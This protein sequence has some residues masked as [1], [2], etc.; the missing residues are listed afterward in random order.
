MIDEIAV[1]IGQVKSTSRRGHSRARAF[2]YLM[3]VG[4]RTILRTPGNYIINRDI[5]PCARALRHRNV[6]RVRACLEIGSRNDEGLARKGIKT[7]GEGREEEE[8]ATPK[9][10]ETKK[11]T[12]PMV[13]ARGGGGCEGLG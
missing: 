10:E 12:V 6:V 4:A 8:E 5:T 13:A 1:S 9:E 3:V 11:L 2:P 7:A